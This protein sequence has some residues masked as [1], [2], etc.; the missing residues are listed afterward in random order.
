MEVNLETKILHANLYVTFFLLSGGAEEDGGE[1][2]H[3]RPEGCG[4]RGRAE[5]DRG[6]HEAAGGERGE[7]SEE[8]GG[9]QGEDH[10]HR[11]QAQDDRK[12]DGV[13]REEHP[14]A[15]PPD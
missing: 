10:H 12:Q 15:Q 8:G 7:G 2:Q 13:W 4:P 9:L 5:D 14:Q 3:G 1:S 11:Q 6:Q